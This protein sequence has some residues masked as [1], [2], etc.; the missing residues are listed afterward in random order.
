MGK[1]LIPHSTETEQA[2]IGSL[3]INPDC[4]AEV[5]IQISKDAFYSDAHSQIYE[6]IL[7]SN[8]G[9]ALS[10]ISLLDRKGI[11]ENVGGRDYVAS[12]AVNTWT[13]TGAQHYSEEITALHKQRLL[14]EACNNAIADAR[15]GI[16]PDESLSNLRTDLRAIDNQGDSAESLSNRETL[17]SVMADIEDRME[18][19]NRN[20]GILTGYDAIDRN[21]MGMEKKTLTYLIGRP[22]MGK[23]ALALNIADNMA[24]SGNGLV[25]FFSLEMGSE[26]LSRRMLAA[27]SK[28]CLSRIR[29]GDF[30]TG[31][32]DHV[33]NAANRLYDREIY[34]LDHPKWK[35]VEMMVAMAEK[36]AGE[37]KLAA[38][39][40]DHV[41]LMNSSRKFNNRHLE[42]S[43]IS[44]E[45]KS[46]SKALEVPV[47]ALSQLS[48]KIEERK[49]PLNKPQL[50]DMKESGDLEQ[51]ADQV[52]AVHRE[53][54]EAV[55]M[56]L[57][58]LKGRD[59]G[60]WLGKVHF[61]R[62]TQKITDWID[63]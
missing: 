52:I 43:H 9:D 17:K 1:T 10:V 21:L 15:N 12:L 2:L 32:L 3:L 33:L 29:A 44:N 60:T 16:M 46:M 41:Q 35:T 45:L 50:S 61:E 13:S 55:E 23:T 4:R 62:F 14:I 59:T 11:L 53:D 63:G 20:V 18:N 8:G 49:P 39:F 22:S 40:V 54:R 25:L 30:E 31:Q 48:R 19:G 5:S 57:A 42:V 26:A 47:I 24:S 38:I 36:I 28:V 56:L 58:G 51:D 37:K 6:S 34:V 27:E 7:K